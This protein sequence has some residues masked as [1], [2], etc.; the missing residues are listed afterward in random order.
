MATTTYSDGVW[1]VT[2]SLCSR[3]IAIIQR[4]QVKQNNKIL[5]R[6]KILLLDAVTFKQLQSFTLPPLSFGSWLSP[7]LAFSPGVQLL[8]CSHPDLGE[9]ISWDLQTGVPV[10]RI[11][12]EW[13]NPPIRACSTTY[14]ICGTMFG[15]L[16]KD[17][18]V[19]AIGTY[20]VLSS[21]CIHHHPIE[22]E[23]I[24][25]IWTHGECVQFATFVPGSIIVWEVRFASTGPATKVKT[26]SIPSNVDLSNGSKSSPLFLPTCSRLAFVLNGT[27]FVWDADCSKLLLNSMDVEDPKYMNFSPDGSFFAC[28]NGSESEICLWKESPTGYTFHQKFMSTGVYFERPIISPNGQSIIGIGIPSLQLWHTKS[29][30]ISPSS[31]PTQTPQS[32]N[33][34]IL[35]FSPDKSL[36]AAVRIG[37]S[38]ATVIDLKSGATRLIIDTGME[39][40]GL[41]VT[42]S[43]IVVVGD[44]KAITWDLPTGDHTLNARV[45]IDNGVQKAVVNYSV[46][47]ARS[48][49]VWSASVSPDLKHIAFDADNEG[50]TGFSIYNMSTGE[51]IHTHSQGYAPWFTPDGNEIW[52]NP[53]GMGGWATI[54]DSKS[55]I[56]KLECLSLDRDPSGGLPWESSHGHQIADGWIL[57]SSGKQLLWLPHHWR[58]TGFYDKIW[59][60]Q[61]FVIL[62]GKLPEVVILKLLEDGL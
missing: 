38:V 52:C 8:T 29:S 9:H 22:G 61:F 45:N 30:T 6:D 3:F 23:V 47:L 15:V 27:I 10:S 31:V 11:S 18:N 57:S 35:R 17:E 48:P 53:P 46:P 25:M 43:K 58:P 4:H 34:F 42:G 7:S 55:N 50:V 1:E 51:I 2:W 49:Q 40:C 60:G 32:A 26:L 56:V 33:N 62:H 59:D 39:V 20:N 13:G 54:K 36:A 28:G 24:K 44:G 14:S 12:I 19:S 37:G 41:G 5:S 21:A 16:F